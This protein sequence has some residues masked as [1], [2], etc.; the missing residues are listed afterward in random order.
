MQFP[1]GH[2]VSS[3]DHEFSAFCMLDTVVS[4]YIIAF[5]LPHSFMMQ[6]LHIHFTGEQTGVSDNLNCSRK[7]NR[8]YLKSSIIQIVEEVEWELKES[9]VLTKVSSH[10][11][12]N[13]CWPWD[14]VQS[15]MVSAA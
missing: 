1:K 13:F 5:N 7:K 3:N 6:I 11:S 9:E 15:D 10:I 2:M 4:W 14:L 12:F 8:R